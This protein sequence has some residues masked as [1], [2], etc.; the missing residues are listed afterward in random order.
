MLT[1]NVGESAIDCAARQSGN[2]GNQTD[3]AAPKCLSFQGRKAPTALLVQN[4]SHLFISLAY[5]SLLRRGNHS[6]TVR[7]SI[8]LCESLLN[9]YSYL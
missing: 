7:R 2:F 3:A 4:R 1:A 5:S 6:V 9:I 8:L